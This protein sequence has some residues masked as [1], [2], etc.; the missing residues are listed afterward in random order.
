M[1]KRKVTVGTGITAREETCY[2]GEDMKPA[3]DAFLRRWSEA[4]SEGGGQFG[5]RVLDWERACRRVLAGVGPGPFLA[6]S[7]E[8][9]AKRILRLIDLTRAGIARGDADEAARM[10]V[11]IGRLCTEAYMK[12]KWEKH[13]MRGAD[14]ASTLKAAAARANKEKQGGATSRHAT[15]QAMA[16]D[17][18][19]R[20]KYLSKTDV[21]GIIAS[22]VGGN[23]NTIRRKITRK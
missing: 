18:W 5:A 19:A 15:W 11:D 23:P 12:G 8:A 6:D 17:L 20:N 10:A 21:A 7:T 16:K 3:M 13:A 1:A 22:K 14:N 9:Y 2:S 4:Q